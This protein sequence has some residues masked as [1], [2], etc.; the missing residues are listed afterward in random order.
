MYR[1]MIVTSHIVADE[2]GTL[3]IGRIE[4]FVDSKSYLEFAQGVAAAKVS[5]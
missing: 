3:K 1:E 5:G 4:E 2:D